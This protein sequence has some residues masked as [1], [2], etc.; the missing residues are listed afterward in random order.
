MTRDGKRFLVAMPPAQ[1]VQVP[2]TVI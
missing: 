2:L 1:T